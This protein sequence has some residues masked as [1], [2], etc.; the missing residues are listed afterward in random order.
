MS[1]KDN[2]LV[3]FSLAGIIGGLLMFVGDMLFYYEPVSGAV[4]NS[5]E[6]MSRMDNPRLMLGGT[7]G[8]VAATFYAAGSLIFAFGLKDTH[9]RLGWTI[10][11]GWIFMF[12]IGGS[13]HAVF[14]NYG[15][16][17]KLPEEFR[18][19]QVN[20]VAGLVG[21]MYKMAFVFG[22]IS[23]L[24]LAY[25]ILFKKTI[26]PKW[27][28]LV[29]PTFLTLLNPIIGPYI[30]HPLGAIVIGGWVNLCFVLFFS[31]T[32]FYFSRVDS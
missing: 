29:I 30:P 19:E 21:M 26:F 16:V 24:L 32:A 5:L 22:L 3:L 17:G 13:Y 28:I 4:F 15:F 11:I 2:K 25:V 18:P 23:S 9:K 12:I 20:L 27:M 31:V 7:V 1:L 14:P 10:T 8:P 6:R